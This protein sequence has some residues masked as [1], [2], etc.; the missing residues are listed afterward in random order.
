MRLKGVSGTMREKKR[1]SSA[2]YRQSNYNGSLKSNKALCGMRWVDSFIPQAL[3]VLH[4]DPLN[5]LTAV[6]SVVFYVWRNEH[7][8]RA[9]GQLAQLDRKTESRR[10][11]LARLYPNLKQICPPE[12]L[13]LTDVHLLFNIYWGLCVRLSL[14]WERW[15]PGALSWLH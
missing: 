13:K 8:L 5:H 4:H 15:L 12:L 3:A 11:Q 7:R 1:I 9:S 10:Q 2:W 14:G 6:S